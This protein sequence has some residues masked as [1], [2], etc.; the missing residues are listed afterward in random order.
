MIWA[1]HRMD[2]CRMAGKVLMANVGGGRVR[3][4][5]RLGYMDGEK[6]AWAAE[7]WRWWLRVNESS[8][9]LCCICR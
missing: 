7:G 8:G 4:R 3:V 6:M 9:E 5:P 1:R 2:E